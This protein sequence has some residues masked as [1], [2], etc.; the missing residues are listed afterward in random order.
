MLASGSIPHTPAGLATLFAAF[1]T[2]A[3]TRQDVAMALE[4]S[5]G[6]LVSALCTQIALV[7]RCNAGQPKVT[8]CNRRRRRP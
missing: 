3:R 7:Q 8:A 4:T 2:H 6:L 5:Q 1:Q